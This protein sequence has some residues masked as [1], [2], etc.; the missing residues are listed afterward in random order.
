[1][2]FKIAGAMAL[3]KAMETAHPVLLEPIMRVDIESPTDTVGAVM[4]DLNARRGRIVSVTALA[5]ME[6]ITAMV[7]LAELLRYATALNAMTGGRA[8]YVMEFDHYDEVPR[9]LTVKLIERQ[10][11]E[12]HITVAH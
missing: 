7:P 12:R 11:A 5:H 8:S 2:S 6:R 1:M 4:G 3:K 10:K 9:D